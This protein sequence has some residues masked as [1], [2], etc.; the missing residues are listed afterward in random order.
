VF[1]YFSKVTAPSANFTIT[2]VQTNN[3]TNGTPFFDIQQ[4]NQV[5]LYNGDCSTSNLGTLSVANGQVTLTV[6]G[7]TTGQVFVIGAKYTT[8]SVVGA[9]APVPATVHYNFVTNVNGNPVAT[10]P[11]GLDLTM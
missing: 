4:G 7:A 11:L 2:I 8:K 3:S 1:F 9:S 5:A 10:D 6:S